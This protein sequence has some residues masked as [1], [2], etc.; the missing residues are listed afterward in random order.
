MPLS[1]ESPA[2]VSATTDLAF[3]TSAAARAIAASVA[4][5][6]VKEESI[7]GVTS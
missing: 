3:A 2:P 7:K 5:S 1:T 6:S 4:S